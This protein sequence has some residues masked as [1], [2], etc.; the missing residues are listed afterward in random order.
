MQTLGEPLLLLLLLPYASHADPPLMPLLTCPRACFHNMALFRAITPP[1][2]LP[3]QLVRSHPLGPFTS[4]PSRY[5]GGSPGKIDLYVGKEVV[6]RAVDMDKVGAALLL[7]H[8]LCHP[9]MSCERRAWCLHRALKP[10]CT[11]ASCVVQWC[12]P[13]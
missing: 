7:T 11:S 4:L 2:P 12:C 13:C 6:R 10:T 9:V 3:T 5:V 8:R 1:I